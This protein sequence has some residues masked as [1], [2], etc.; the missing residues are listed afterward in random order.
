VAVLDPEVVLRADRA[1][2]L[3]VGS[4]EV[5]GAPAVARRHEPDRG[6]VDVHAYDL[7]RGNPA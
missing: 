1:A 5:R 4:R 2:V 7:L 3:A 6:G